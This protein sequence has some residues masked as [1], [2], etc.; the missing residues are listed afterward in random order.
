MS[1]VLQGPEYQF[2]P[3][4]E[5]DVDAVLKIEQVA[6]AFPWTKGIFINCLRV[7]YS[8]WVFEQDNEIIAYGILSVAAGECHVL[9]LCVDPVFQSQG[10]GAVVLEFLIDVA[11]EH[12][13][14]TAFL[15]VRPSNTAALKLYRRI[16]FDEVGLRKNYYP[17]P[18]GREDA[19]ILAR[20]LV[21]EI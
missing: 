14:D 3:M 13:A 12:K 1:A 5:P 11:R 6:Y 20:S 7:G 8:C 4:C 2:R 9:N 19:V 18:D 17:H 16:G 21:S 10:F 15:E